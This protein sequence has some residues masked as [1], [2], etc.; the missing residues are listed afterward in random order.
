MKQLSHLDTSHSV[1]ELGGNPQ[2][3]PLTKEA[4]VMSWGQI[5]LYLKGKKGSFLD[6]WEPNQ[7]FDELM[8]SFDTYLWVAVD[9]GEIEGL[10]LVS[11]SK[12]PKEKLLWITGV[13]CDDVRKYLPL[14]KN[15]EQW[16]VMCEASAVLFEGA[17]AWRRLLRKLG[18]ATPTAMVKK[19]LRM[20]WSN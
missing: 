14:H 9:G 20:M 13:F 17:H 4:L 8:A 6:Q 3:F 7:L 12:T 5:T 18:Y 10:M 11:F 15:L 1:T 19:D 16:A 2:F